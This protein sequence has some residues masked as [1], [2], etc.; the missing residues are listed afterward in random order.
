MKFARN[1]KYYIALTPIG[2]GY[3]RRGGYPI[4]KLGDIRLCGVHYHSHDEMITAWEKR[5]K[6][7]NWNN[8]FLITTDEYINSKECLEQFDTLPYPKVV[9]TKESDNVY[10]FQVY[11]PGFENQ[12]HVGDV[13]RYANILGTRKFEKYFDCIKWLNSNIVK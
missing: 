13:L 7:I 4:C 1:L 6:R 12:D 2:E 5:K 11:V 8:I 10:D 9:F 3:D